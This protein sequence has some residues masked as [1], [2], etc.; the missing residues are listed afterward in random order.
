MT[1]TVNGTMNGTPN[2]ERPA[3]PL[4]VVDDLIVEYPSKGWRKP[5]F[6]VLKGVSISIGSRRDARAGR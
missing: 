5:P 4:L 1:G 2:K 6:R 3:E